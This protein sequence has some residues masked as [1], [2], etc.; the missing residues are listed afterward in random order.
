MSNLKK[1]KEFDI[2]FWCFQLETGSLVYWN[3]PQF[4]NQPEGDEKRI[5]P[6]D[7]PNFI[8]K[9]HSAKRTVSLNVPMRILQDGH[10]RWFSFRIKKSV[11]K[12]ALQGIMI[13]INDEMSR[14][15][16][17]ISL[18]QTKEKVYRALGHDLKGQFSSLLGFSDILLNSYQ[19]LD[20]LSRLKYIGYMKIIASNTHLLVDNMLNWAKLKQGQISIQKYPVSLL[21]KLD[22]VLGYIQFSLETKQIRLKRKFKSDQCV[23]A[24][25]V[26]L[27]SVLL[28]L[29]TNAVKFSH[30]GHTVI[31]EATEKS[32][33]VTIRIQDTGVGISPG[34]L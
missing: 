21:D 1:I 19:E 33:G 34:L 28:N 7:W 20:E 10:W 6:E 17:T 11:K 5:H 22:E 3:N 2:L 23:L 24:D 27:T 4:L 16:E 32:E 14:L 8:E 12:S 13:P 26:L 18:C 25:S 9:I 30:Q 31:V 29:I 15:E